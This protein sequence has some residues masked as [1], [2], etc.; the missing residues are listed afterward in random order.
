MKDSIVR[1]EKIQLTNF[2]NVE[3]GVIELK[4]NEI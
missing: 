2:K 1:I 4:N 3:N